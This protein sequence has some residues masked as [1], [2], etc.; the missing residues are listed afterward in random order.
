MDTARDL[1]QETLLAAVAG[2]ADFQGRAALRTWCIGILT[3]KRLDLFRSQKRLYQGSRS[4][5]VRSVLSHLGYYEPSHQGAPES[6][7]WPRPAPRRA[8]CLALFA[9]CGVRLVKLGGVYR[10]SGELCLLG[11]ETE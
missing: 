2:R 9:H 7:S 6:E 3:H 1:V 8:R 5:G 10:H 11:F 4:E